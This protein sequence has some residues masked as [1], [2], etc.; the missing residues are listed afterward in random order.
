MNAFEFGYDQEQFER[1]RVLAKRMSGIEMDVSKLDMVYTRLVRIV[2]SSTFSNF[3]EYIDSLDGKDCALDTQFINAI[4]TNLTGFFR[5][6]HHFELLTSLVLP[7][8]MKKKRSSKQITVWSAGCSTGEE[9]YTI[10]FTLDQFFQEYPDWS[11]Q[12][13]ASDIDTNVLKKAKLGVYSLSSMGG[14]N[15][16][17]LGR[18]FQKG[19]GV[20]EGLC[21]VKKKYQEHLA[22]SQCNLMEPL[23]FN[24]VFDVIFCR[25]VL[26]YFDV[27]SQ[28]LILDQFMNHLHQDGYL[29]TGHSEAF[30]YHYEKTELIKKT[31]YRKII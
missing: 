27:K 23:L 15:A 8:L 6:K 24:Q 7:E 26:I 4:T 19:V 21:R 31:I 16:I 30:M 18:W 14:M 25:N 10:A 20:N 28:N 11:Y 29:F 12:I 9:P 5:E 22:F 13:M 3:A 1:I 17:E 2:R